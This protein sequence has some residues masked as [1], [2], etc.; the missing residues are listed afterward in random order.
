MPTSASMY[1]QDHWSAFIRQVQLPTSAIFPFTI[2]GC[3]ND[4]KLAIIG[5]GEYDHVD[6]DLPEAGAVVL[7]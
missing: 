7:R 3:A 4:G 2:E 5:G 6:G 1:Q